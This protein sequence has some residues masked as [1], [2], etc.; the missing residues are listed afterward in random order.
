MG[1]GGLSGASLGQCEPAEKAA[2]FRERA[3][4]AQAKA[5]SLAAMA[6]EANAAGDRA[7]A[8]AASNAA[9]TAAR[10][11]LQLHVWARQYDEIAQQ[12]GC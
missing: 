2:A 12:K 9:Q 1:Y 6:R 7:G 4:S 8:I 3:L 11:S 10:E 5:D